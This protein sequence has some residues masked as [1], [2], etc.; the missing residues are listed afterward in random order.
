MNALGQVVPIHYQEPFRRGYGSY[1]PKAGDYL[2]DA[3]G[4]LTAG[5]AG[6]CFHNG[7]T[8]AAPDGVPRRCFD[9]R[10]R[11]LFEQLDLE[12]KLAVEQLRRLQ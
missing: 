4:A 7:D 6:W 8:R 9:L 5:A 12:E 10:E 1:Q 11:R 3:R 2:T